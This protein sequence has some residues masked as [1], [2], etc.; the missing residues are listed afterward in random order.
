MN[1][2]PLVWSPLISSSYLLTPW[3]RLLEKLTGSQLVKIFPTFYGTCRF[4]AAF[5]C[6]LHRPFCTNSILY[7]GHKTRPEHCNLQHWR[8][9]SDWSCMCVYWSLSYSTLFQGDLL[10]PPSELVLH[11]HKCLMFLSALLRDLGTQ[12][13]CV[14]GVQAVAVGQ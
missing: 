9:N 4:F 1:R 12:G 13:T 10:P 8:F 5:T 3:S 2:L 6:A 14:S 11:S 7:F